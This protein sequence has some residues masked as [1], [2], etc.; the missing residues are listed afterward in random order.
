MGKTRDPGFKVELHLYIF[1]IPI[2][3]NKGSFVDVIVTGYLKAILIRL[4]MLIF[5]CTNCQ[6][7]LNALSTISHPRCS[8]QSTMMSDDR[9]QSP[10]PILAASSTLDLLH[11]AEIRSLP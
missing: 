6:H 8:L 4:F 1:S 2:I 7:A 5:S 9:M 3:S 11:N 10:L